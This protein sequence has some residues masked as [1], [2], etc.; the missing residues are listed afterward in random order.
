ML[1]KT[2]IPPSWIATS[3]PCDTDPSRDRM[4]TGDVAVTAE[5][6]RSTVLE[7][8]EGEGRTSLRTTLG[9]DGDSGDPGIGGGSGGGGS[10]GGSVVGGSGGTGSS[11]DGVSIVGAPPPRGLRATRLGA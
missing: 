1:T 8:G 7:R 9:G 10:A 11:P 5:R 6:A 2:P 4:G 3:C